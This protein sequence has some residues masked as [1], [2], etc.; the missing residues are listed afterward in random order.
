[1]AKIGYVALVGRPNAGKSTLINALIGAKVSA[2][3]PRPQTTQR[4]I[5]GIYTDENTWVQIV[6]LDTP[7]IHEVSTTIPTP[8]HKSPQ[9]RI[10]IHERI[11]SEAIASLSRANVILRLLDPTRSYGREDENIEQ[12]LNHIW[13]PII[14][15][16]TKQ[17][18]IRQNKSHTTEAPEFPYTEKNP[19]I[20]IDSIAK[21]GFQE[22]IDATWK[23]LHEWPFLYPP[24]YYTDQ[25]ID[26][27]ISEIIREQLFLSLWEEIPYSCY[28]EISHIDEWFSHHPEAEKSLLRIQAY[29]YVESDSQKIIL[30]GKWGAKIQEIGAWSR[31]VL[32]EIFER[33]VFLALRVKVHRHWRKNE[34]VLEKIFTKKI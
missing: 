22:L 19:I 21:T 7:G 13:T 11:N 17:D 27:R 25:P 3:S 31:C 24:D 9:P 6:F 28:V 4:S 26:L 5:P 16:E 30:I 18:L 23:Y 15:V 10:N 29:I 32:E 1:M 20:K 14:Y 8:S 33:K 12:I 2:V 34:Q